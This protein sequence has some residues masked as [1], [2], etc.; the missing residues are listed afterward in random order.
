MKTRIRNKKDGGI[1]ELR[2]HAYSTGSGWLEPLSYYDI[3]Q[4]EE[5]EEEVKVKE[6]ER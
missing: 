5:I 2:D 6:E 4:W 1:V 3:R